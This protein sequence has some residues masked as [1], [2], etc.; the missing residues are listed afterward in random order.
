MRV[1]SFCGAAA[2]APPR[3]VHRNVSFH[4]L[5]AAMADRLTLEQRLANEAAA[6]RALAQSMPAGDQRHALLLWAHKFDMAAKI[7]ACLTHGKQAGQQG[8]NVGRQRGRRL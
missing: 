6:A 3:F 1:C 2:A 7:T 5:L 8:P 4:S